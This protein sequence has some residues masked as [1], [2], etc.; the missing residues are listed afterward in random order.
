MAKTSQIYCFRAN[1]QKSRTF[2]PH[3]LP[4][5]LTLGENWQGYRISTLP[6]VADVA[7][8]LGQLQVEDTPEGWR[9]Y[10]ESLGLQEV[11]IVACEDF[12]ADTLYC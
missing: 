3:T 11:T 7:K 2:N 12:F 10:L 6:W 5:W 9:T 4:E 1:Y 8:V